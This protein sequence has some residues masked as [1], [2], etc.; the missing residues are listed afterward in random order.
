MLFQR[1]IRTRIRK[2]GPH[3]APRR[4]RHK[5]GMVALV[6]A[7]ALAVGAAPAGAAV[8]RSTQPVISLADFSRV[9]VSTLVRNDSGVSAMLDT[10]ELAPGHVVTLWCGVQQ[11]VGVHPWDR[12]D[13]H[14]R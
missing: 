13:H 6:I 9:G 4:Y 14:V 7:M 8:E 5:L 2:R 1:R 3:R 11:P 10:T 12:R